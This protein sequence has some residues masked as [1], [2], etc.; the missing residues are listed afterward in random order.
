MKTTMKLMLLL[1][2]AAG[3]LT[4]TS[5]KKEKVRPEKITVSGQVTD[6]NGQPVQNVE[7]QVCYMTFMGM[8]TPMGDIHYTDKNGYYQIGFTP[9]ED[10]TITYHISYE[11][12][13]DNYSYHH[14]YSVDPWVAEQEHDVVLKKAGE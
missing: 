1:L 14:S 10:H 9:S 5:C 4:F 2:V 8:N 11:I 7:V 6:K 13:I 12:T 3:M